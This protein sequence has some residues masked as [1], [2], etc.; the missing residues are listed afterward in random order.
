MANTMSNS[1]ANAGT[2]VLQR[3]IKRNKKTVSK[4]LQ[5]WTIINLVDMT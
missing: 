1:C 4:R 3:F 2:A 5:F